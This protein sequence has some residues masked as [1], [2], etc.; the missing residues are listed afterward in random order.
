MPLPNR[1]SN[2]Y[3]TSAQFTL[4]M[5]LVMLVMIHAHK[6][7]RACPSAAIA[8]RNFSINVAPSAAQ[9]TPWN[10]ATILCHRPA[11]ATPICDPAFCTNPTTA[12]QPVSHADRN[13]AIAAVVSPDNSALIPSNTPCNAP[14]NASA[15]SRIP[16]KFISNAFRTNATA[17]TSPANNATIGTAT[18]AIAISAGTTTLA[19]AIPNTTS[20]SF[21]DTNDATAC[22]IGPSTLPTA[23]KTPSICPFNF[24]ACSAGIPNISAIPATES[25]KAVMTGVPPITASK[26]DASA[27]PNASN[28]STIA[29]RF[30]AARSAK[31][32]AIAVKTG[33]NAEPIPMRIVL[34]TP[35][36]A[37]IAPLNVSVRARATS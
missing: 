28:V 31:A 18:L 20:T 5:K 35:S 4:L 23:V 9:S 14:H 21:H 8:P 17:S 10:H 34:I 11:S 33:R 30:S 12:A 27:P 1:S 24:A 15:R 13:A 29:G 25:A 2:V 3:P 36:S 32:R 16:R 19:I 37:S 7:A 22:A 6:S 26:N